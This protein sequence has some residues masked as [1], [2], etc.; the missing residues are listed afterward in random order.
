MS[1]AT[2]DS[3]LHHI[4]PTAIKNTIELAGWYLA[5]LW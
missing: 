3:L 1:A 4:L 2:K 5:V